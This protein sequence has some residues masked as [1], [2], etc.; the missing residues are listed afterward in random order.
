MRPA[1]PVVFENAPGNLGA[2]APDLSGCVS[3]G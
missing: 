1:H 3:V 2:Y